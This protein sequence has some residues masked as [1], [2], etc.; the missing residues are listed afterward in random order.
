MYWKNIHRLA[1][2]GVCIFPGFMTFPIY[3]LNLSNIGWLLWSFPA[4]LILFFSFEYK[5]KSLIVLFFSLLVV[6]NQENEYIN[7]NENYSVIFDYLIYCAA[8]IIGYYAIQLLSK[9]IY[10][11]DHRHFY[12]HIMSTCD[13]SVFVFSCE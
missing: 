9:K 11:G 8:I 4:F 1:F 6:T 3:I 10:K 2:I 7:I 13:N 12:N 5:V